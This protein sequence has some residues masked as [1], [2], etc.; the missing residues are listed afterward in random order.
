MSES[1]NCEGEGMVRGRHRGELELWGTI[2]MYT[3]TLK[4]N[5]EEK[6]GEGTVE[7]NREVNR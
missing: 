3:L 7:R 5:N 6:Y 4:E 2:F 1:E